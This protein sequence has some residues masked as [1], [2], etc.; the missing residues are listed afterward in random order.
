MN[1]I[2]NLIE[3]I[4]KFCVDLGHNCKKLK[5]KDQSKLSVML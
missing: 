5:Y 3:E 1:A 4:T 2:K